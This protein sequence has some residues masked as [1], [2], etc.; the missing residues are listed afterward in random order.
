MRGAEG[1]R[2]K[3]GEKA[4][5]KERNT[6]LRKT[7]RG[8]RGEAHHRS[9]ETINADRVTYTTLS[10]YIAETLTSA[11]Y[12]NLAWKREGWTRC[13]ERPFKASQ[14]CRVQT[15]IRTEELTWFWTSEPDPCLQ[16]PSGPRVWSLL[17]SCVASQS[18]PNRPPLSRSLEQQS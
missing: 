13:S 2:E 5:E 7:D 17:Q 10:R 3:W 1:G 9:R 4:N 8:Y 6:Y 11:V 15:V 14:W 16:P 12:R 18:W